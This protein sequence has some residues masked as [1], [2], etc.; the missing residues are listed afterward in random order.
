[1]ATFKTIDDIPEFETVK[2]RSLDLVTEYQERDSMNSEMKDIFKLEKRG[3]PRQDWIKHTVD[4]SP[5]NSLL[6]AVRLMTATDP[7][8]KV[9]ETEGEEADNSDI[10]QICA[11]MW[12]CS[13]R[14]SGR[15]VHYDVV[16]SGLLYG[17]VHIS[18]TR[19][20]DLVEYAQQSE[21]KSNLK[22]MKRIASMTPYI[23]RALDPSFG[24]P[25]YD[26]YGMSGYLMRETMNVRDL[27]ATWGSLAEDILD[28]GTHGRRAWDEVTLMDYWDYDRRYVWLEEYEK[29]ILQVEHDLKR[30]PIIAQVAEGTNLF[31]SPHERRMPFLYSAWRSGMIERSNLTMTL[32]FSLAYAMGSMPLNV[33]EAN[34]PGKRLDID[35]SQ[36]GGTVSVDAGEKVYPLPKDVIDSSLGDILNIADNKMAES[37]ISR[38]ALG[39]PPAHALPFQAISLLAQQGRLPLISVKEMSAWAIADASTLALEWYKSDGAKTKIYNQMSGAAFDLDPA[40]IPDNLMLQV[41]MEPQLPIDKLQMANIAKMVSEGELPLASQRW[42]RE[43]FLQIGSSEEMTEEIWKEQWAG[44][45]AKLKMQEQAIA[46]ETIRLQREQQMQEAIQARLQPAES[47]NGVPPAPSPQPTGPQPGAPPVGGQGFN[48]AAGGLSPGAAGPLDQQGLQPPAETYQGMAG[49]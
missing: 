19:T 8:F 32:M 46:E 43:T 22:R 31:T 21:S 3:L 23:F 35:Y 2:K 38:Q 37:M 5:R 44:M 40:I 26:Q 11:A 24:Y 16:L 13:G 28:S 47:P 6:G 12:A 34:E 20:K 30:I 14:I 41:E 9:P 7:L 15:P 42:A 17:D 18:V 10:E 36:P 1:M 45:Y 25:E 49:P 33:Y 4:P 48:P 39:E 29:P 27:L